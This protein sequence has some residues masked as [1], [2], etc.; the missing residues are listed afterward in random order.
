MS[1]DPD[2]PPDNQPLNAAPFRDQFNGLAD[3]VNARVTQHDLDETIG[4]QTAGN[5]DAVPDLVLTLSDPPT[6]AEMEAL[7]AN[8]QL[9]VL[10]MKRG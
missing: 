2:F 7:L 4:S 10:R 9:L 6:K 3:L 5:V 1:Y 8:Y